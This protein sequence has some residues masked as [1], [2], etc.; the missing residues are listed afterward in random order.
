MLITD[1]QKR[2]DI[3]LNVVELAENLLA[4]AFLDDERL[5]FDLDQ[6]AGK[7]TI[8][9]SDEPNGSLVVTA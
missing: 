2:L 7:L 1:R 8:L 3:M 4:G 5:S 6:E 9:N